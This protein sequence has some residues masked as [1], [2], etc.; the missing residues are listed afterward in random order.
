MIQHTSDEQCDVAPDGVCRGCGAT[1]AAPCPAC[2]GAAYHRPGCGFDLPAAVEA[3]TADDPGDAITLPVSCQYIDNGDTVTAS[4]FDADGVYL[5][6]LLPIDV[7]GVADRR[8]PQAEPYT[9]IAVAA[10]PTP[11]PVS[12]DT[13]AAELFAAWAADGD[14]IVRALTRFAGRTITTSKEG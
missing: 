7:V 5:A 9:E 10:G 2:G 3:M 14:D 8:D 1:H 13:L 11:E 6:G 4:I 12:V